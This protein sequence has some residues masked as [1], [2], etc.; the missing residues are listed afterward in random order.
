MIKTLLNL[1]EQFTKISSII[2]V[3]IADSMLLNIIELEK[4]TKQRQSNNIALY[5]KLQKI[6]K[7]SN[8]ISEKHPQP[9]Q[10]YRYFYKMVNKTLANKEDFYL[11]KE[12]DSFDIEEYFKKIIP[13]YKYNKFNDVKYIPKEWKFRYEIEVYK[14]HLIY[15]YSKTN[16]YRDKP[17]SDY[18]CTI[19]KLDSDRMSTLLS[20]G[21]ANDGGRLQGLRHCINNAKWVI[22]LQDKNER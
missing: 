3:K 4:L 19:Y 10:T 7:I 6:N 20:L 5:E 18:D 1:K 8:E 15:A 21:E 11:F 14:N 13:N 2:D 9:M 16:V 22:D 17:S 12:K